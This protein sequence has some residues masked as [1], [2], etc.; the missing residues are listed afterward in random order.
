MLAVL[1][2]MSGAERLSRFATDS[3]VNLDS[4]PPE[5]IPT[6]ESEVANLGVAEAVALVARIG[7]RKG[8]WGRLRRMIEHRLKAESEERSSDG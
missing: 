7:R 1:A 2:S 8:A 5:L 3:A 4:V 6:Q